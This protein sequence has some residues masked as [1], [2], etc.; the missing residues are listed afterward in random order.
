MMRSAN[1]KRSRKGGRMDKKEA[2]R[3][4]NSAISEINYSLT[5][6]KDAATKEFYLENAIRFINYAIEKLK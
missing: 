3:L 5:S 6:Y 2:E 1:I 4:L